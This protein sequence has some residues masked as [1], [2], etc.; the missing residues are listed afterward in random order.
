MERHRK[1]TSDRQYGGAH[2]QL[3]ARPLLLEHDVGAISDFQNEFV[4]TNLSR[5]IPSR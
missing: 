4:S 3:D 1:P 2:A 5:A